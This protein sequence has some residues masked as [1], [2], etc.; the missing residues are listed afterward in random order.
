MLMNHLRD[1][2]IANRILAHEGVVDA[3]GHVSIRHPENPKRFFMS[4]ARAPQLVTTDDILEF[5]ADGEAIDARGHMLY[6]E[7]MIHAGVYER[8]PDINAVV[9]NHAHELIPFGVTGTPLRP[10]AHV[11]AVIGSHVPVW[12]IRDKFGDT[13]HLVVTMAQGRDLAQC[14]GDRRVALMK[15]HGG[16]VAG[17][18]LR[19]AVLTAIYLQVG[20]KLLLQSLPLGA[21]DYLTPAE[22]DKCIARQE[23]PLALERAWEYWC[24]RSGAANL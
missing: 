13:D 6:G 2:V 3:F 10:V 7:R 16:V 12:D 4:R 11:S 8:R 5:A 15:R 14:L 20:A 22:I 23:S 24:L 9:H 1:L 17:K 19:D 18:T 21:P